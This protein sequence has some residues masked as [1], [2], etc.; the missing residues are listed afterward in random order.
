MKKYFVGIALLM[1]AVALF[2]QDKKAGAAGKPFT[3]QGTISQQEKPA[4]I[5]LRMRKGGEWLTDSAQVKEGKFTLNG[6]LEEPLLASLMLVQRSGEKPVSMGRDMLAVFLDK[7][8]IVV[9]TTDSISKAT[10]SGSR[11]H[12]DYKQLQ[13]QLK[14]VNEKGTALQQ[15]YREL[16]K[17]KDEEGIKKL[18]S[19]FDALDAEEKKIENEFF[20]KNAGSPIALYVL[21]QV[22]GYDIKPEQVTPLYKKLSKEAKNSPSGKEFAKRL[23]SAR[24]TAVGQSALEFAQADANG[25]N[26]S[27]SSFR[28]KYVLVDFWASW[29][30]PC[31]AENPNVVKAYGKFKDKGFEILG[32]SLDDKKDKW[33]AAVEADKLTWA[34][35]SDLKGW[36]NAAAE[37]YGVRAIPQNV[38]IDPK[39]KIVAK[40]LRGEDLEKKLAEV[41]P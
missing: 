35:V 11:A 22:A 31:R 24:K 20:T 15:Q 32:V 16:A 17:N 8:N 25:K 29:C 19:A 30:G 9:T 38:L 10:V 18:E 36:K 23:E 27:L 2:A 3:I 12:E 7:G 41:L 1:P 39:G 4:V 33:L 37:L 5:F 40:N 13:E 26:I 34:H 6:T 28:G 14:D 21:N